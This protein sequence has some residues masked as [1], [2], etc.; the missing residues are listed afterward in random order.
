M[1]RRILSVQISE[2]LAA[3]I[4]RVAEREGMTQSELVRNALRLYLSQVFREAADAISHEVRP[5]LEA[6]N[7]T[8]ANVTTWYKRQR[9]STS[10][11]TER[12]KVGIADRR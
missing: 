11:R 12:D 6:E 8:E 4:D 7:V 2:V 3:K 9:K 5:P 10:A 1:E